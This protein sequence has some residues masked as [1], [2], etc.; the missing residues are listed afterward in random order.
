MTKSIKVNYE[1]ADS[2]IGLIRK[3]LHNKYVL[4]GKWSQMNDDAREDAAHA[5]TLIYRRELGEDYLTKAQ[6]D[7][8][9]KGLETKLAY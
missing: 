1:E 7:V 4:T 9:L 6:A 3:R 2:E 5:E 8:F